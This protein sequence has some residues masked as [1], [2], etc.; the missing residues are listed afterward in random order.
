M[1]KNVP[2][3][4]QYFALSL[5]CFYFLL[6]LFKFEERPVKT[7]IG[8]FGK[9]ECEIEFSMKF[10]FKDLKYINNSKSMLLKRRLKKVNP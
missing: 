9:L 10:I 7:I 6:S 1:K 2:G 3:V 4:F 8:T 5:S